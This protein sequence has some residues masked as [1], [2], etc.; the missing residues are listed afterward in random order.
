MTQNENLCK[1][2]LQGIPV[3]SGDLHYVQCLKQAIQ[4]AQLP[5][6]DYPNLHKTA[7]ITIVDPAVIRS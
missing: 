3:L 4:Q 2:Q 5:M 6:K 1:L 7:P